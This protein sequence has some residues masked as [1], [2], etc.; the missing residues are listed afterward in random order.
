MPNPVYTYILDIDHLYTH[1][2]DNIFCTQFKCQSTQFKSQTALYYPSI[3][4]DQVLPLQ[5]RVDLGAI[6]MNAYSKF[7]K[8]Q[9]LEPHHQMIWCHLQE[10]RWSYPSTEMLSVYSTALADC[11]YEYLAEDYAGILIRD[12]IR[13][14]RNF[15]LVNF[16]YEVIS[17][18]E[19]IGYFDF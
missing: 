11:A 1:F 12:I 7:P 19:S 16:S 6:A 5:A 18:W 9:G 15:D 2:V 4:P 10:N 13:G 3:R 8:D 17:E 14:S